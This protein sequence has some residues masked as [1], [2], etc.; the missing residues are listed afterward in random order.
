M[1]RSSEFKIQ[2]GVK[3]GDPLSAIL[4]NCILDTAFD[5]W[6]LSL[7]NEGI[8]IGHG[9]PRL[10]NI[11]YADDMILYAK[12][13]SE[14]E[15]MTEKLV[16]ELRKIG[17]YLN[18]KK[19]KILRC[20]PSEDDWSLN[21]TEI[22]GE[23]VKILDDDESHRYLGKQLST[24]PSLRATIEFSNRK[25][26]A[27]A[28]FHKHKS[29]LLDHNVPLR[30]RLKY[31]DACIGSS[32]LFAIAVLP[33]TKGRLQELDKLQRK[34]LRR[35]VGWRRIENEDWSITMKRMNDRLDQGQRLF[36]CEP[37]SIRFA[38][39]QWRYIQH[40]IKAYPLLWT[41]ILYKYNA[42]A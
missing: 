39:N 40:L 17:L 16:V 14:L 26:A 27:W 1:N 3:Q 21:F 37:W 4:F 36:Y 19:T 13:L 25:R 31:F 2:R 33:M 18:T 41:R 5:A 29:A 42:Y 9:L 11:R 28:S 32:I 34:M 12:S 6:R 7:A 20:N 30:L 38:R 22:S 10:T 23:F 15:S 8:Y 24:S 35:I